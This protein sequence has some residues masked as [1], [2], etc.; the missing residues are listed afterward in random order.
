MEIFRE[1]LARIWSECRREQLDLSLLKSLLRK[2]GNEIISL[3]SKKELKFF[4]L[5]LAEVNEL[6]DHFSGNIEYI[7]EEYLELV[8]EIIL[9]H[10]IACNYME[11]VRR[12]YTPS[13][14]EKAFCEIFIQSRNKEIEKSDD[15]V[16]VEFAIEDFKSLEA[17]EYF[18]MKNFRTEI[19]RAFQKEVL[20]PALGS[21]EGWEIGKKM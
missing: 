11:L 9:L 4:L 12:V 2:A 7:T 19:N 6:V 8:K 3:S 17:K 5:A 13:E 21:E 15:R 10:K 16:L 20:D 1:T 18:F 14:I